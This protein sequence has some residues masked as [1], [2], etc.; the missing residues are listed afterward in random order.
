MEAVRLGSQW[1]TDGQIHPS[2]TRFWALID[3]ENS[4]TCSIS[5]KTAAA[6]AAAPAASAAAL[7]EEIKHVFEFSASSKA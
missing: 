1:N 3:A 4:K 2:V 5:S 6:D 7:L